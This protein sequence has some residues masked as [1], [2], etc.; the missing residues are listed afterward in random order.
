MSDS[1]L[2]KKKN[3]DD[4]SADDED[5]YRDSPGSKR[6]PDPPR[7]PRVRSNSLREVGKLT[8]KEKVERMISGMSLR[9]AMDGEEEE[10]EVKYTNP[11]HWFGVLVPPYLR[12]TQKDFSRGMPRRRGRKKKKS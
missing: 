6:A 3:D 5:K 4:N 8:E 11:L 1:Y 12:Q 9:D 7:A 2:R 10:E